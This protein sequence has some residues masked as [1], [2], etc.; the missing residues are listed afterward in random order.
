MRSTVAIEETTIEASTE[1]AFEHIVPIDL[2]SIFT[3]YGPLVRV[4]EDL[5]VFTDPQERGSRRKCARAHLVPQLNW[6][7]R[8]CT[9]ASRKCR[10]DRD[11]QPK[12][13]DSPRRI[14]IVPMKSR[15]RFA[16]CACCRAPRT[17]EASTPSACRLPANRVWPAKFRQAAHLQSKN[18]DS[19]SNTRPPDPGRLLHNRPASADDFRNTIPCD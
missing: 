19:V 9:G 3:G 14:R 18:V 5:A 17:L 15:C 16:Q 8:I 10:P 4:V 2:T 12:R 6:P 13:T 11:R 7:V 1:V